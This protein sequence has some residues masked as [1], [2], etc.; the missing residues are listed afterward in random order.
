MHTTPNRDALRSACLDLAELLDEQNFHPGLM[1]WGAAF[2]RASLTLRAKL[3]DAA[4]LAA[5]VEVTR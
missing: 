1:V 3:G 2:D 5:C 4:A